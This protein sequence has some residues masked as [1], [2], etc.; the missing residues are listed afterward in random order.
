MIELFGSTTSPFVRHCRIAFKQTE[1]AFNLQLVDYATSGK[2]SPMKKVPYLK[3]DALTLTDSS[4]IIMHIRQKSG[5]VF[6]CSVEDFELYTMANTV[7]DTAINLFLLEK[8]GVTRKQSAYMARQHDRLASGF[9][10]LN[11]AADTNNPLD[12][13]GQIRVACLVDWILFRERYDLSPYHK[14]TAM[15][16]K[17]SKDPIF[18]ATDPRKP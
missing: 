7:A 9:Q 17:A 10:A 1:Q 5:A 2:N 15:L 12:T 8:D 6:P 11:D 13:D 4:S 14:L 18:M 16:A 3:D